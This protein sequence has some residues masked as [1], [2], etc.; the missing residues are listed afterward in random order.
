MNRIELSR[1]SAEAVPLH[2]PPAGVP[3]SAYAPLL[4]RRPERSAAHRLL[5]ATALRP[6][7]D[8]LGLVFAVV[9]ALRW[10][11]EPVPF[12]EGW[13]LLVF[14]P[15]VMVLLLVRG[16][17]ERRLRPTILDGVVPIAGSVSVAAMAAVVI[18]SYLVRSQF[19]PAVTAHLWAVAMVTVGGTRAALLGVQRLARSRGLDG[20][21]TL[22][23]GAGAVGTRLARRLE[24][25][26]EYG[27]TPVGFLDADPLETLDVSGIPVLGSP[28]DLD[29]VAQITGAEHVVIAFSSEPDERLVDL[30]RRCEALG[31]EVSLVPRL[32]ESLNHRATYEPLGGT[33]LVGLRT[34]H[35]KGWQFAVKHGFDRLGA[36]L[37]IV[38]FGP[39]MAAIAMAVRLSSP[40]PTIFRQR[41]VGRDGTVFDLYKFRSMRMPDPAAAGFRPGE[42]SAPGGVEGADRRTLIGRLLRRTSLDELPQFFNV[43]RGEMSLIGPRPERP[44][45][46]ELFET[47]IRRYGD[48][49]R[50]KSGLTGWAQV[51]GLRGQT[52]LSDRVEWDNYYIEH[53]SLGLDFKIL[54]LT[55]LAVLRPAE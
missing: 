55:V 13:P 35:P 43:L 46:V 53:W 36:L 17:Y 42:G 6:G 2:V 31:L 34:V 47:D 51:H 38:L 30:V 27:L 37:L 15:L 11:Q 19:A 12:S 28:D 54:V 33:P 25:Q 39:L 50:V 20:R 40:G 4:L 22:I 44:E 21:P 9:V 10:P 45:F 16:M 7:L 48:R 26:P 49:H 24:D 18:E 29:W 5:Q 8:L 52:S 32:F 3:A 14:P 23:V 41:R 1:Q